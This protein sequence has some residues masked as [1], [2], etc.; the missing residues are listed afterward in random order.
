MSKEKNLKLK[1]VHNQLDRSLTLNTFIQKKNIFF[2][3][4]HNKVNS[5]LQF[6]IDPNCDLIKSG[7]IE[8]A[9]FRNLNKSK[10]C[11]TFLNLDNRQDEKID[12]Q[13][14]LLG[15]NRYYEKHIFHF[16][17]EKY[18]FHLSEVKKPTNNYLLII[19]WKIYCYEED[20]NF[21]F[22][23]RR[24]YNNI[25]R[26]NILR[27]AGLQ[28]ATKKGLEALD[29]YYEHSINSIKKIDKVPFLVD[30]DNSTTN[31][32]GIFNEE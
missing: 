7:K 18:I 30:E 17:K 32:E 4:C 19:G 24:C 16:L 1:L 25:T 28:F 5:P 10:F 12:Y 9:T 20:Y 23:E 22:F 27:T 6:Q 14:K 11:E 8:V 29:N 26:N 13:N 21:F 15:M 2:S 31:L 3:V